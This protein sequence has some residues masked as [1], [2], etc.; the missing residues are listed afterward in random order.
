MGSFAY[1]FYFIPFFIIFIIKNFF[2][3]IDL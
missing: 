3:V 1:L 2:N